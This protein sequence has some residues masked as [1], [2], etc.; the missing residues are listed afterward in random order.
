MI[1][2]K[3]KVS[4]FVAASAFV[5]LTI[6]PNIFGQETKIKEKDLPPAVAKAF[7]S[8]YPNA[9]ILGTAKETEKGVTYFEIESK[10]G[11]VRRDLLFTKGGQTKEIEERLTAET[12]P[13]FVKKS[14]EAKYK[15]H[16]FIKG[17]KNVS[18]SVTKYEIM[19]KSG[20]NKYEVVCDSKGNIEK[21][22]E[23]SKKSDEQD[24]D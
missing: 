22:R 9:K 23:L 14:I 10:D 5:L 16:E 2:I 12:I 20:K 11:K 15:N 4:F 24:N 17:E 8:E 18:N 21:T 19:I 13:A 1:T 6:S 7:H 3:S